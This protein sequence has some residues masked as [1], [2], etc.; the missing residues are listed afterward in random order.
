MADQSGLTRR[1]FLQVSATA[2]GGLLAAWYLPLLSPPAQ[3]AAAA[4]QQA[5]QPNAFVRI[6]ADNWTT[7]IV[8][9]AEL[10]QG[11]M[12]APPMLVA[13]ELDADWNLVRFEQAPPTL[14]YSNPRI[15]TQLTA[16]SFVIVSRYQQQREAGAAVRDMLVQAAARQWNVS[17][18]T[19]QTRN[20]TV[21]DPVSGRSATYGSLAAAA[22]VLPPLLPKLKD[23]KDF[24]IIGQPKARLDGAQKANGSTQYGIDVYL[25]GMLTA[26]IAR[27]P[28]F[29][30]RVV[31]YDA[32]A[33]MA[34]PGVVEVHQIPGGV[35]VV[36]TDFWAAKQGRAALKVKWD[37]STAENITSA[38]LY[39]SY[40]K[41]MAFPG[42]VRRYDG[43]VALAR[44]TAA[45]SL[46]ADYSFP[47]LAHA[48]ME[49][50]NVVIDYSPGNCEIW[51]G[52]QWPDAD[53][54]AAS[55]VLGVPAD[56][57][58]FHTMLSGGGFGRRGSVDNDFILDAAHVAKAVRGKVK[59]MWTREDDITGGH[60]RP[61]AVCRLTATLDQAGKLSSFT[62]RVAAQ[63]VAYG[64]LPELAVK[65]LGIDIRATE[66]LEN[67]P[68][69]V[70]NVEVDV[71]TVTN[72]VKVLWMRS[73]ANSFNIFALETFVDE[74]AQ[75]AGQD[76]YQFRRGLLRNNARL[77]GVLDAAA[78]AAGWTTP[79]AA[80]VSR[81]IAA[82]AGYG[83]YIAQVV[84]ASVSGGQLGVLRGVSAVDC[85]IAVNPDLVKAQIESGIVFGLSSAL[86][87][88]ITLQDGVVQ[89]SNFHDYP[90]LRM[91]QAPQTE[92][93]IVNSGESPGGVGEL[94]VPCVAPALANA[95]YGLT[96]KR[97]RSLPMSNQSLSL[98]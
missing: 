76:P 98:S 46:Q 25:P 85:G 36:G 22:A 77:L 59:V 90:V 40:G 37:L 91:H 49:P 74:L 83:S 68:Y 41:L 12:T 96:G 6:T 93:V 58:K 88:A 45:Q 39:T 43:D 66:G 56:L 31:S 18:A 80:G 69:A 10:G 73:V 11:T 1:S 63:S 52:T 94:G 24:T 64:A 13:E 5:F 3:A 4:Q 71:H 26:L 48:P 2:G 50:L 84:E 67:M 78:Q 61:A 27:P 15:V 8:A 72:Q 87:G 7:V 20:S 60:Y 62:G 92:T 19:L 55:T 86:M 42:T 34:L 38:D 65:V 51:C 97:V 47:Y 33:A 29:G 32:S 9:P 70:P 75:A 35:A 95:L 21:I 14:P 57:I 16:G 44:A 23:P 28:R 79:P 82:L 17:P 30:G 81:G 89:Q 54:L 53:R